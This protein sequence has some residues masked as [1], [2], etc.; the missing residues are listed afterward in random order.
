[1]RKINVKDY[2]KVIKAQVGENYWLG[3]YGQ[4]ANQLLWNQKSR[5]AGIEWWYRNWANERAKA[6]S[7][8]KKVF[9]CSGLAFKYPIWLGPDGRLSYD[10]NTDWNTRMI[11]QRAVKDNLTRGIGINNMPDEPG[12]LV[13][14]ASLIHVGVYI[15]NGEV[16]EARGAP[17]GVIK[18]KLSDYPWHYWCKNPAVDYNTDTIAALKKEVA[19]LKS[20]IKEVQA[21]IKDVK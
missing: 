20:I 17:H 9:D 15:G 12:M 14:N 6:I 8:N 7:N 4:K 1:M 10:R 3:T 19:N 5:Q 16:V 21:I 2:L 11:W 18:S 13:M